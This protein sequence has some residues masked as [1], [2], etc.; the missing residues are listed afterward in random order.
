MPDVLLDE[1]ISGYFFYKENGKWEFFD[2]GYTNF[3]EN[4]RLYAIYYRAGL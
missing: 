3:L 2:V 4:Y 1:N